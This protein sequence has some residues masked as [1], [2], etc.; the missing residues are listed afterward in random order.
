MTAVA[1]PGV[2]DP[3]AI[4]AQVAALRAA[5]HLAATATAAEAADLLGRARVAREWV[6]VYKAAREVEVEACK[7]QC[8]AMRRIGQLDPA[9]AGRNARHI[10]VWLAG[11]DD[12]AFAGLL[13]RVPAPTRPHDPRGPFRLYSEW[14]AESRAEAARAAGADAARGKQ[15]AFPPEPS[16]DG[17]PGGEWFNLASAAADVLNAAFAGGAVTVPDL[18]AELA[19]QLDADTRLSYPVGVAAREGFEVVIREAIRAD[20]IRGTNLD[21]GRGGSAAG[22]MPAWVTYQDPA[23][24]WVRVPWQAARLAHVQFMADYREAQAAEL[25]RSAAW[26]RTVVGVLVAAEAELPGET[27]AAVLA[28]HYARTRWEQGRP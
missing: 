15:K 20:N 2:A 11:Y 22:T 21:S 19:R 25:A 17:L 8:A 27:R 4:A 1:L 10:A 9:V 18:A 12:E 3:R 13:A 6:K 7:L 28:E 5:R 24:G 16:D 23:A 14:L 26:L